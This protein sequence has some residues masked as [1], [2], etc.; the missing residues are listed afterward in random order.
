MHLDMDTFFVSVERLLD[1]GLNGRPVVVGGT[2]FERGVVAGCSREARQYGIHS[3]MPLRRAWELCP[4]AVFLHGNHKH[5]MEYSNRIT[6]ILTDSVPILEKASVDEFYLDLS[7]F[8]R[9]MGR[10]SD[11]GR[12]LKHTVM[13]EVGLPFTYGIARNKLVAKVATNIGKKVG[14]L[15]VPEGSEERFMAPHPIRIMPGI[16]EVTEREM[17]SMGI[18]LI[19]DIARLS[20]QVLTHLYGKVGLAMHEHSRGIDTS[21]ILPYRKQKS[22]GSEHTFDE[23][24]LDPQVVL[25]TLRRLSQ[26]VGQELRERGFMTKTVTFKL[27]YADFVTV[28][29]VVHCE[30]TNADLALYTLAERCFSSLYTRRVRVRLVGISTS[31][32]TEDCSQYALFAEAEEKA[33]GLYE[34]LDELRR[35]FGKNAIMYG[36][37]LE[38]RR[39]NSER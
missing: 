5:Y 11:W 24:V 23:D 7:G 17:L 20:P 14:D 1:P 25:A 21:P 9:I 15:Y 22:L 38:Q 27:R 31:D 10:E 28:T 18:H 19:G 6:E 36:S 33:D 13:G 16:G 39:I 30:Y 35:R 3:A 32:L 2:P 29:K 34:R 37:V 8:E 26:K 4:K 12:S